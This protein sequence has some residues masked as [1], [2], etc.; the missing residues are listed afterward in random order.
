MELTWL[1]PLTNAEG[2]FTSVHLDV[3]RADPSTDQA[4]RLRWAG[5]RRELEAAGAPP[6]L[7]ARIGERVGA[8]TGRHGEA[9]RS[10]V[11]DGAG[12]LL[13]RV[14]PHRPPRDTCLHGPVPDLVPIAR[15]IDGSV[16]YLL[17]E[18]DRRG[19]DI[20]VVDSLAGQL[21]E[22]EVEGGH[23]ELHKV[24]GGGW[25]HRRYQ[26]RVEDS[27]ERN[28]EAVAQDLTKVVERHRPEL[29]LVTGDQ[30]AR[31][32]VREHLG[33]AVLDL[34]VPL[35][36]GGRGDGVNRDAVEADIAAALDRHRQTRTGEALAR[37]QDASGR[38]TLAASGPQEVAAALTAGAVETLLLHTETLAQQQLWAGARAMQLGTSEDDVAALGAQSA[39]Q[40]RADAVLVRALV[41]QSG[42]V[43]FVEAP[44][45]L[46][47][48]VGAV[49]RFDVRP[50]EPGGS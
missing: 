25:A 17:V 7:V 29:I 44:G 43:V 45:M 32:A 26:N 39:A 41:A 19:G 46:P 18:V 2:P 1:Q 6:E 48:D 22:H 47:G 10:V 3:T 34:V 15:A 36:G 11:A 28:A 8:A 40:E 37:F 33:R 21:E 5:V 14:M 42:D 50:G 27:W 23:D 9:S 31:T 12:V 49:L 16:T 20:S 13:D 38:R 35:D 4:L 30:V 24:P